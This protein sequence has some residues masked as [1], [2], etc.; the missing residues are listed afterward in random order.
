MINSLYPDADT[1]AYDA[2]RREAAEQWINEM[3][4]AVRTDHEPE[5]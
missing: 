3:N 2:P 1:D 4:E 5:K